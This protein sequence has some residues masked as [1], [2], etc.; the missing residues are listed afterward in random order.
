MDTHSDSKKAVTVMIVEDDP[1]ILEII[2]TMCELWDFDA[3]AFSDGITASQYLQSDEPLYHQ[4]DIALL[5]I[6]LPQPGLWGHEI[7]AQI[8]QHPILRN[9]GVILMTAYELP[10]ADAERYLKSS[11]ADQVI[12]KPLPPM[13]EMLSHISEVIAKRKALGN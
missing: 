1:A 8:R 6:R 11:G 9:I 7:A 2:L 3:I 12:R 10:G 4:P 13:D 5:D